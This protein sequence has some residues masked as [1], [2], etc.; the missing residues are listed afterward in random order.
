[1]IE[2][3]ITLPLAV[4]AVKSKK[5]RKYSDEYRKNKAAYD[6]IY[7]EKKRAEIAAFKKGW[8]LRNQA[9]QNAK[10]RNRYASKREEI[11]A[12]F[13]QQYALNPGK[14]SDMA[15]K[16]YQKNSKKIKASVR[17]YRIANPQKIKA[18]KAAY[19]KT[20]MGKLVDLNKRHKRRAAKKA[21][22]NPITTR[23]LAAI[24]AKAG[25]KCYYCRKRAKL[26]I[27]HII[28]LS[29]G[30]EHSASNI[31]MACGACNFSK[32][33]KDAQEFAARIGLLFI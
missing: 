2:D 18:R 16:R 25:G 6:L 23:Q 28:P 30:G 10:M 33:A 19:S 15:R 13:K 14:F 31:V 29:K 20:P 9:A 8:Y 1:M 22:L 27:E 7:R 32:G 11:R 21:T 26:T 17:I 5:V 3:E 24:K 4:P 12:K